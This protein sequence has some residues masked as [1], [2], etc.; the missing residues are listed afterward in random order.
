MKI[1]FFDKQ[2]EGHNHTFMVAKCGFELPSMPS[3]NGEI[4]TLNR[5]KVDCLTC[6][7]IMKEKP[8]KKIQDAPLPNGFTL[9]W[10]PNEA[11]G[12]TY[13]SDEIGGGVVVWDTCLV[14]RSTLL[15]A[16]VKEEEL[17]TLERRYKESQKKTEKLIKDMEHAHKVAA[18]S[19][20]VFGS[21]GNDME[22]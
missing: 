22:I 7:G 11:G 5:S 17:L 15:G 20:L 21:V 16:I 4:I 10:K 13:F 9:F 3:E 6:L 1:H 18:H 2:R 14:D 8:P 12:R 19:T